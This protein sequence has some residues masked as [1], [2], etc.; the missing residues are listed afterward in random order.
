MGKPTLR[1]VGRFSRI[2][3]DDEDDIDMIDP[4]DGWREGFTRYLNSTD[5][6]GDLSIVEWWGVRIAFASYFALFS[7]SVWPPA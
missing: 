6:L 7:D 2:L 3:S 1:R 4:D 5:I